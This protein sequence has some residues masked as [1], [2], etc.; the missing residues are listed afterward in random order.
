MISYGYD[1]YPLGGGADDKLR[2]CKYSVGSGG[3]AMKIN[4]CFH[5]SEYRNLRLAG[6]TKKEMEERLT[7]KNSSIFMLISTE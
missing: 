1:P 7:G 2:W 4:L 6:K 3:V 5:E